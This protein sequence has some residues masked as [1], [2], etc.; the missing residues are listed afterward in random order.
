MQV[1]AS[2][3]KLIFVPLAVGITASLG[4]CTDQDQ[5]ADSNP[6]VPPSPGVEASSPR[7][8]LAAEPQDDETPDDLREASPLA[9]DTVDAFI[10]SGLPLGNAYWRFG[11]RVYL[12]TAGQDNDPGRRGFVVAYDGAMD[13]FVW[14]QPL[15]F[16]PA[17]EERN[18]SAFVAPVLVTDG[19]TVVVSNPLFVPAT[20]LQ[21]QVEFYRTYGYDADSGDLLWT[22]DRPAPTSVISAG[23]LLGSGDNGDV[24][25]AWSADARTGEVITSTLFEGDSF[26]DVSQVD[27]ARILDRVF[28]GQY[29]TLVE[30]YGGECTP[31]GPY[32][33]GVIISPGCRFPIRDLGPG[34]VPAVPD[35]AEDLPR[36]DFVLADG[37]LI[38][39]YRPE[40][41]SDDKERELYAVNTSGD[42]VWTTDLKSNPRLVIDFYATVF[43]DPD[44][45]VVVVDT[46]FRPDDGLVQV[47]AVDPTTGEVIWDSDALNST[48]TLEVAA[49]G[50]GQII[51]SVDSTSETGE[52]V[53]LDSRSGEPLG[54]VKVTPRSN[55]YVSYPVVEGKYQ[56]AFFLPEGGLGVINGQ[57]IQT[58][59][60]APVG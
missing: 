38:G 9:A 10:Q 19:E 52:F 27:K 23:V 15:D 21:E 1:R 31:F 3:T 4:G 37:V 49:V 40:G 20:G 41:S 17:V 29:G 54:T 55:E 34:T 28:E 2:A 45:S 26:T 59:Q 6:V 12:L 57:R 43:Y 11:P 5:S 18:P 16:D 30:N 35:V 22:A 51:V 36:R 14:A 47:F 53:V 50:Y 24:E 32:A 25:V 58:E 44:E 42:L 8:S 60:L 7:E 39:R 48:S 56:D 46:G 33:D 13:Q